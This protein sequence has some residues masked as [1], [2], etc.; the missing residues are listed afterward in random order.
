MITPK[1]LSTLRLFEPLDKNQLDR[2]AKRAAD[3]WLEPGEWL[4]REGEKF[5]FFVV[6]KGVLQL[7]KDVMGRETDITELAVGDFFGEI[8]VLLGIPALSSLRAKTKCRVIRLDSQ[9]LHEIIQASTACG[10]IIMEALKERLNSGHKYAMEL[11]SVRVHVVGTQ[12]QPECDEIRSFLR[13]NQIPYEWVDSA[14][15]PSSERPSVPESIQPNVLVDSVPVEHPPSVRK[16]AEALGIPTKPSAEHYDV[17]VVGGGP[18]GLA[19]AVYGA[20]EGLSILL[21]ERSAAGGQAGTSSRIENYLGFP[22]GISGNELSERAFKQ[23]KRFG[24]EMIFTRQVVG[25]EPLPTGL[26]NVDLD[27][28]ESVTSKTIIVTTGVDWRVLKAEGVRDL[29]GKG[30]FYG[31]ASAEPAA[32]VGKAVY[33]VGGGNSAGQ[34]AVFLSSYAK[35]VTLLVRGATL[36][37]SMSQYLVEQLAAKSNIRVETCTEVLSVA[38]KGRLQ[39]IRTVRQGER[40]N[41]RQAGLLFVMIGADAVTQWLPNNLQCDED[42]FV[43][44]GRDVTDFSSWSADRD[45]FLLETNL[46]GFFCAGDVRHGSIKRVASAVGEGSMAIAVIHQYLALPNMSTSNPISTKTHGTSE[47]KGPRRLGGTDGKADNA[48][49]TSSRAPFSTGLRLSS[50]KT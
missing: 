49:V 21:V 19:A 48:S 35:S 36:E 26:Y 41:V 32:S 2:L 34:A 50:L 1:L 39:T 4:V 20:S 22:N 43:C 31:A 10:D 3:I 12:Y 28:N 17:V 24:A 18:A 45:P 40:L 29:I 37:T 16:V 38:G 9:Q 23:A 6:L 11:P 15:E 13:L 33:I 7:T 14:A 8:S 47:F 5:H 25:I 27:G 30:V 44:T 42:G 46:P